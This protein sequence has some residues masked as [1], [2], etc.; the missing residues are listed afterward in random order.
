MLI[1]V[2]KHFLHELNFDY[3]FAVTPAEEYALITSYITALD[4]LGVNCSLIDNKRMSKT[5]YAILIDGISFKSLSMEFEN[6]SHIADTSF[7]KHTNVS[8]AQS[9]GNCVIM[10][11]YEYLL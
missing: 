4:V 5:R 3:K 8:K 6:T 1:A 10:S 7:Q 2:N 11:V 9:G